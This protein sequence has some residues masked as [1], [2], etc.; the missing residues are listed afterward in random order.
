MKRSFVV[1]SLVVFFLTG[2]SCAVVFDDL[3]G[4]VHTF[5]NDSN[6][7][8]SNSVSDIVQDEAGYIWLAS[9]DGLIRFDGLSF[10]EFT[11]SEYGFTGTSPRVL[12]KR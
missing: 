4:S 5:W 3:A 8:P 10:T 7:L 12:K 11:K 1:F 2:L 9:Y 6:G